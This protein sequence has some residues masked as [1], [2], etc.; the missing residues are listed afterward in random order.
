MKKED[1]FSSLEKLFADKT[2]FK[3]LQKDPTLTRLS[4]LRNYI[5]TL[6]KRGE[7]NEE[8]MKE[9]KPTAAQIGRAHGLPKIHKSYTDIP[10][11]SVRL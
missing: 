9:T 5:N 7:T 3:R 11:S 1:Y 4:T 6:L 2:K 8:Q 10:I